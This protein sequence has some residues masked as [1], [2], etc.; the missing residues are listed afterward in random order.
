[1]VY[2]A[3]VYFWIRVRMRRD[4]AIKKLLKIFLYSEF[5][6]SYIKKFK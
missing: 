2:E 5:N 1:M 4:A 6:V 3:Q